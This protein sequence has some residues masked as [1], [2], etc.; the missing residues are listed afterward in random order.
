MSSLAP[1]KKRLGR[2]P[3]SDNQQQRILDHAAKLFANTGYETT[4]INDVAAAMGVSKAAIYHYFPTKQ[5]IYDAIILQ[6]LQGLNEVVEREV[7][8]EVEPA[9]KLRRFMTAHARYFEQ[10]HTGFVVMLVGFGGMANAEFREE[11]M[12]LRDEYEG[13]LRQIVTEAV[14]SKSFRKVDVGT[15]S[16]AVLS[17]LNWMVRWFKPGSGASAEQLAGE[18][19]DLLAGGLYPHE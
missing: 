4:S 13:L 11:A 15:T 3:A 18:Y 19:F 12:R 1:N 8:Q 9:V 2:P 10:H 6:T 17:M 5:D 16:R 14:A 7:A